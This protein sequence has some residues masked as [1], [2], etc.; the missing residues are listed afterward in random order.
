[1]TFK[2][3][4]Q[5]N[6]PVGID[7]GTTYSSIAYLNAQGQP[8]TLPNEEG[9]MSTPSVVFFDGTDVIVGTEA[10]RHS[11]ISPDRVVQ[12]AKRFMGDRHKCW[13]MNGNI[14]R[15][16]D[17]S[18]LIIRKL[19][20]AAESK[21]GQVKQAVITVPA[22]FSELQR[23]DTVEA[24]KQAGLE[25]V[26]IIN[27]PVAA[28]ICYVLGE[29]I[30]FAEIA[31]DQT[32]LVFDLG[33][34]TFDLSLV[35]YNRNHVNVIASGGDLKLGGLDWNQAL[36]N[37]ICTLFSRESSS[38]PRTD[39]ESLQALSLE[40]EQAKRSLSVRPRSSILVQHSG[41]RC[42][43]NIAREEFEQLTAPLLKRT[44]EITQ[45]MLKQHK[46]GWAHVD[47]VL[48]TGGASRMP[49]I[50]NMLKRIS[51]TTPNQ[52]LSPDQSISHGAAYYAGILLSERKSEPSTLNK[53]SAERLGKFR[54]QSVTGRGL[55]ILVRDLE[56]QTLQPHILIPKNTPLP[57]AYRQR[58]GTVIENQPRVEL[59]I[60][61]SSTSSETSHV[62]IGTCVID[63]LPNQL[64]IGSPI[65]VTIRYDEQARVFVD[66]IEVASG[67]R[68]QT[69]I[70]RGP[71]SE[72]KTPQS[73]PSQ[74]SVA[75]PSASGTF[76][77][78]A[79]SPASKEH[80]LASSS[81]VT[82]IA[83]IPVI[84]R[85]SAPPVTMI[86]PVIPSNRNNGAIPPSPPPEKDEIRLREP[87]VVPSKPVPSTT[88]ESL[89]DADTPILL[90]NK[91]GTELSPKGACPAC[92]WTMIKRQITFPK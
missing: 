36:S 20:S 59:H 51:G 2:A 41:R 9:E 71:V 70:V 21:I 86:L 54:Q 46:K 63:Q 53:E 24:G 73:P 66:A 45:E 62:E 4:S 49:S 38:D 1:M 44:E 7:L 15:P 55:G 69:T 19:L 17:I 43:Y 40:I 12:F 60:I 85:S 35:Q 91:C 50:R 26:Q 67:T 88:K 8:V 32:V 58:F 31:N 6:I 5:K 65:E 13:V 29:G 87:S 81:S 25:R 90:C 30:W 27:E 57:C 92:G 48:I 82:P 74:S 84:Q 68:A 79:T 42:S 89:E 34:G 11:V 47:T 28:A 56:T 52:T 64:P 16:K 72:S 83:P 22:E 78:A 3:K 23:L 77:P 39:R 14:Y 33:G 18:A 37:H 61:E 75:P 80:A 10:V 76:P